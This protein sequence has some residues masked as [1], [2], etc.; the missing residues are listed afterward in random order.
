MFA[1]YRCYYQLCD[2]NVGR[3]LGTPFS[4]NYLC[5][6]HF[7]ESE[8]SPFELVQTEPVVD[9]RTLAQLEDFP[10]HADFRHYAKEDLAAL[11]SW[12]IARKA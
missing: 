7:P 8:A 3:N 6:L 5:P 2:R 10:L 12:I 1:I 4:Y 11:T 9:E